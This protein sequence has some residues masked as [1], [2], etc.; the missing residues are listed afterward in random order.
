MKDKVRTIET[1]EISQEG[2]RV[3]FRFIG[4][5]FLYNMVR[6]LV[7]TLLE[8]GSGKRQPKDIMEILE[9]RIAAMQGKPHQDRVCIFGRYIIK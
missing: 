5:G 9:K 8:V 2:D 7:G 4:N 3:C 6:I 1:I